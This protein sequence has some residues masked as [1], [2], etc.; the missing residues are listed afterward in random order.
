[1]TPDE[2]ATRVARLLEAL[3]DWQRAQIE[4]LRELDQCVVGL[5]RA[6][7]ARGEEKDRR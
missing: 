2:V 7:I 5:E 4:R 6:R 1:M 3:A